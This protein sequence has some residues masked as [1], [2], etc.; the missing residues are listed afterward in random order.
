[1]PHIQT[2]LTNAAIEGLALCNATTPLGIAIACHHPHK[3]AKEIAGQRAGIK[4]PHYRN[5]NCGACDDDYYLEADYFFPPS[6]SSSNNYTTSLDPKQDPPPTCDTVLAAHN[7]MGS[8]LHW[9]PPRYLKEHWWDQSEFASNAAATLDPYWDKL[10]DDWH[11]R[12]NKLQQRATTSGDDKN[13]VQESGQD[14][15]WCPKGYTLGQ[16]TLYDRPATPLEYQAAYHDCGL[17]LAQQ[18]DQA[19]L[20]AFG[21][22]IQKNFSPFYASMPL[23]RVTLFRDP[24]AWIVSKFFWHGLEKVVPWKVPNSIIVSPRKSNNNNNNNN[25]HDNDHG[26]D[27]HHHDNIENIRSWGCDLTETPLIFVTM[28][29]RAGETFGHASPPRPCTTHGLPTD[30]TS[31]TLTITT[32]R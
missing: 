14:K 10:L 4:L 25:N 29:N 22:N 7:N 1:M 20:D 31:P 12:R 26:N 13:T 6:S 28:A 30:G 3:Q 9:L 21:A 23:H 18:A 11:R 17:E 2:P 15:R 8:E 27:H 32:I 24:W 16:E 19:F 5:T